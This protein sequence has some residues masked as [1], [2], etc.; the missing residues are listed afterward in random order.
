[1]KTYLTNNPKQAA[2]FIIKSD[3]VAFPTETVYGLGA[4]VFDEAAVKK[5]YRLKGRPKDNPLIVHIS[6]KKQLN[7]LTSGISNAANELIKKYF[8]GPL[9]VIIRKNDIVPDIV[10]AGLD[11]VAVRMPSSKIA[12]RFINLCGVPIAAPSAN[13]SGAPSPTD[14]THVLQDFSGKVS[15]I[16]IGPKARYGLESTV[17]DC[18]GTIPQVLRPGIITIEELQKIDKRIKLKKGGSK[19]KSPGTKYRHYSPKAK[20]I[21]VKRPPKNKLNKSSAYMG[22]QTLPAMYRKKLGKYKHCKTKIEYA[23][24]LYSFFRECDMYGIKIIY[25]EEVDE[26]EIGLAVMNRLKKSSSQIKNSR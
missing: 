21:I 16:L 11:T 6:N 1:M 25:A 4:N 13:L 8:P 23:K 14:F 10:T 20:V 2:K 3:V 26:K 7:L 5:I 17:I 22:I 24:S 15:C 9:T 18:S 12:R 19:V